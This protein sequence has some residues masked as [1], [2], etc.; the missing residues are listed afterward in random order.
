[1][2]RCIL[3]SA[4]QIDLQRQ[5]MEIGF[6]RRGLGQCGKGFFS[7]ESIEVIWHIECGLPL[8]FLLS[9]RTPILPFFPIVFSSPKSLSSGFGGFSATRL[10]V[11][12][13]SS[14][15]SQFHIRRY[16]GRR[17]CNLGVITNC[18]LLH[19]IVGQ[20]KPK[21]RSKMCYVSCTASVIDIVD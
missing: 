20:R 15:H 4:T 12:R 10:M 16:G 8:I 18:F 13:A 5:V 19:V 21:R 1:M 14:N 11:S 2:K 17:F 3:Q 9:R 7:K 6:G